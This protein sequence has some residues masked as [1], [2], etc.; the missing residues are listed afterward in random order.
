L[1]L[2][3]NT[4][5]LGSFLEAL[6][7]LRAVLGG[8]VEVLVADAVLFERLLDQPEHRDELAEDQHLVPAL[9]GLFQQLAQRHELAGVV[10]GELRGSPR[11]RGSHAAWRSG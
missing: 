11:R 4:G 5:T 10:V 9:D 6:D 2:I 7:P 3:K 1:R 8:A